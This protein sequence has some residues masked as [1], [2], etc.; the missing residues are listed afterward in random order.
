M[1][2]LMI[3]SNPFTNDPRVYNEACSLVRGGHSVNVL[4]WDVKKE[5]SSKDAKDGINIIRSYNTKLMDKVNKKTKICFVGSLTSSFIRNDYKILLKHF[6]VELVQPPRVKSGFFTWIKFILQLQYKV[7]KSD[8][9]FSWFAGWHSAFAVFFSKLFRKKSI[10]VVGGYDAAYAPEINYGAFTNLKEKLPAKY[11]LKNADFILAVSEYIKREILDKSRPKNV[12]VIYNGVE[13]D[14][15]KR[16]KE[17]IVVTIGRAT[18]QHC[19]LKGL[20]TFA[21]ASVHLSNCE[22]VIIGSTEDS[23]VNELKKINPK[24]IFTGEISHKG[25]LRW[26]QRAKVYC[27]LS[28]IESFGL[29]NAEAMS[30]ECIPV[31]T[32]ISA[33]KEVV[34][35]NGFI[36]PYGDEI[37]T[38]SAIKNALKSSDELGDGARKQI[39]KNFSLERREK[40]LKQIIQKINY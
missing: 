36:V 32:D 38:V 2:I 24:I 5:N 28:Y 8:I 40:E 35:D 33:L 16:I 34:A 30:C 27:Q 29:G 13:T 20:E 23:T 17:K 39:I 22:F 18:K 15:F 12:T 31:V 11:V 25:V 4:A 6:D 3:L 19:K 14:R 1:N 37:R 21:K 9:T 10:V 26:L 7:K